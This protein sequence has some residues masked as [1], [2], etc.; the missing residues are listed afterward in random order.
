MTLVQY[1]FRIFIPIAFKNHFLFT[2][3]K[4]YFWFHVFCRDEIWKGA[5]KMAAVNNERLFV[6]KEREN[7]EHE[8]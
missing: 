2:L 7:G 5:V 6:W 8:K 4:F 3:F 1:F